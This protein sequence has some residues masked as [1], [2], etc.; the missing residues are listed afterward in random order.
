LHRIQWIERFICDTE[1]DVNLCSI[2]QKAG[3]GA[4][5]YS[6]PGECVRGIAG[7]GEAAELIR[8]IVIVATTLYRQALGA[9][10]R[11]DARYAV[12]GEFDASAVD[13]QVV[14]TLNSDVVLLDPGATLGPM[15][16]HQLRGVA[17]RVRVV[18]LGVSGDLE[19]LVPW[20]EAGVD[21]FV[22]HDE[23]LESLATVLAV[24]VRGDFVF[25]RKLVGRLVGH[26]VGLPARPLAGPLTERETQVVTLLE[27]GLSNK[28][29]ARQLGIEVATIKNHVHHIL[30]KLRVRRRGEVA[31]VLRRNVINTQRPSLV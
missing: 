1:N 24:T 14:G 17:P 30:E 11:A 25:P 27:R 9:M 23:P 19:P 5:R 6:R 15:F 3:T 10:L 7:K 13:L 2:S 12:V 28:E 31:A 21:G 29:I 16:C 8:L 4:A 26:Y 22:T 20:V 18:L